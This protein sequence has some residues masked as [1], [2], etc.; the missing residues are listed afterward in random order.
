MA[1]FHPELMSPERGG[2]YEELIFG[3]PNIPPDHEILKEA[4]GNGYLPFAKAMKLVKEGQK[5]N[6]SDPE[7]PFANDL[8]AIIAE[9]LGLSDYSKLNFFSAVG[10]ALD[11]FH[12]VDGFFVYNSQ[13][14]PIVVTLDVTL[15]PEK[16]EENYKADFVIGPFP[17]AKGSTRPDYL[18][19]LHTL[20]HEIAG[21]IKRQESERARQKKG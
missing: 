17:D 20:A 7:R 13:Y 11:H 16:K 15:D 21:D 19:Q 14:G 4:R 1:A 5:G 6:P 12:G 2:I 8:H 3:R 9:E 10:T 18:A